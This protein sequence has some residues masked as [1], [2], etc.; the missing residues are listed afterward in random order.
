MYEGNVCKGE[1]D[2]RNTSDNSIPDFL[3]NEKIDDALKN[4][5]RQEIQIYM[6]SQETK[7]EGK[8][9]LGFPTLLSSRSRFILHTVISS[10][11]PTLLTFS[12]GE[13]P[14]R[15]CYVIRRDILNAR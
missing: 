11:F 9:M 2:S 3:K 13:E 4:V 10:E 5:F 14:N 6:Y 7:H 12:I 1:L 15:Q 8:Q